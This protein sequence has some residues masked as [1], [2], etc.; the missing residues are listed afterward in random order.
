[1]GGVEPGNYRCRA[2]PIV[3]T[4]NLDDWGSEFVPKEREWCTPTLSMAQP[5][6]F[7][8]PLSPSWRRINKRMAVLWYASS[9]HC[10]M[11]NLHVQKENRV[12][13]GCMP[14]HSGP[15]DPAPIPASNMSS[16]SPQGSRIQVHPSILSVEINPPLLAALRQGASVVDDRSQTKP[17]PHLCVDFLSIFH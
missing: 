17:I 12:S 8:A 2:A 6:R 9:L 11:S 5:W 3:R 13:K 16:H 15:G 4:T 7:L 10:A 14:P 1:M